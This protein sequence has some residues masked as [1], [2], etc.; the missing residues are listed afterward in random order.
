MSLEFVVFHF[1]ETPQLIITNYNSSRSSHDFFLL[2]VT[3]KELEKLD[4]GFFSDS[5]DNDEDHHDILINWLMMVYPF[6]A[7]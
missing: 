7:L 1:P 5:A 6:N 2:L 4:S 3:T